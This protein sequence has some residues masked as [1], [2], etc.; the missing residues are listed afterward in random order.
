MVLW[1]VTPKYLAESTIFPIYIRVYHNL[2]DMVYVCWKHVEAGIY[3][4]ET[5]FP[6]QSDS[7]LSK[8]FMSS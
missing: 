1:M 7:H 3:W 5:P 6:M 4:D 8:L 2:W